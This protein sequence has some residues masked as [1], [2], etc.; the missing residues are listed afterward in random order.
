LRIPDA[1]ATASL[2][3]AGFRLSRFGI[4]LQRGLPNG[5]DIANFASDIPKLAL[6]IL[7]HTVTIIA[8]ASEHTSAPRRMQDSDIAYPSTSMRGQVFQHE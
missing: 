7:V 1:R 3:V 5:T 8:S 4:A 2:L 6:L